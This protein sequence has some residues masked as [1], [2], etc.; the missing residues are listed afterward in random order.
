[1]WIEQHNGWYRY[2]TLLFTNRQVPY[3]TIGFKPWNPNPVWQMRSGM[4]L[5]QTNNV[6]E[7]NLT[8]NFIVLQTNNTF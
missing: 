7:T 3:D 5:P 4:D 6:P 1:M 2:I 8:Q